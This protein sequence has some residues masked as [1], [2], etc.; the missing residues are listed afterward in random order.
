MFSHLIKAFSI[1][2]SFVQTWHLV[3][4]AFQRFIAELCALLGDRDCVHFVLVTFISLRLV[5]WSHRP[6]LLESL[7]I[8]A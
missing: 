3:L 8:S 1:E 7:G 4:N 6:V 5:G 2:K